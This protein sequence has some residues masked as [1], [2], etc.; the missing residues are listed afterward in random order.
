MWDVSPQQLLNMAGAHLTAGYRNDLSRYRSGPG[1]FK[2]DYALSQPIPWKAR[3]CLRAGTVHIGGSLEEIAAS[4]YEVSRGQHAERPF[5]LLSQPTLFDPT[6]APQGKHIAWTYCHVPNGSD[7]DM[8]PRI[9][10]QIERFAPGFRDC[11]LARSI[12]GPAALQQMNANLMGG[13][14]AGGASNLKQFVFRPTWRLYATSAPDMYLC[15]ASTPPGAGV[16][17]MCGY[18]AARLALSRLQ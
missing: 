1:V 9:E 6:R 16:H 15:S 2:V 10:A 4:E 18:N 17:G 3:E 11:V 7:F 12:S 14:I 5:V 8:L 13:D